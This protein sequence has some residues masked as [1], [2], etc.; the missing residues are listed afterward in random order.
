MAPTK[1]A[2][3]TEKKKQ[4]TT[5]GSLIIA[6]RK[7]RGLLKNTYIVNN[8]SAKLSKEDSRVDI[9]LDSHKNGR[10]N[11]A[12]I[13]AGAILIRLPVDPSYSTP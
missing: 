10:Y 6:D 4:N 7:I 5:I 2:K 13:A 1:S 12:A 9:F 11:V 3:R 8:I